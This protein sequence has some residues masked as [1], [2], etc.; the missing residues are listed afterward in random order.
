VPIFTIFKP[1]MK[2][3]ALL[4]LCAGMFYSCTVYEMPSSSSSRVDESSSSSATPKRYC[5]SKEEPRYCQE[6]TL[7]T[8]PTGFDFSDFC[9]YSSSSSK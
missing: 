9:P 8:C 5:I 7:T 1:E 4:T 3:L 2:K 6:T